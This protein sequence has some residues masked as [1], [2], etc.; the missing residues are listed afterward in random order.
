MN[1]KIMLGA[2]ALSATAVFGLTGCENKEKETPTTPKYTITFDHDNNS[3]TANQVVEVEMG[4]TELDTS[5]IPTA[6]EMNG[7]AGIWNSFT[8]NDQ[9][10]TV[11]AKYG[12]GTPANPFMVATAEQFKKILVEYSAYQSTIYAD[13]N[14]STVETEAEAFEKYVNYKTLTAVYKRNSTSSKWT[15][16]RY[17]VH[18]KVYFKM[19]EDIDLTATDLATINLAGGYFA[20]EI[21]GDGHALT[22]DGSL[23]VKTEGAMFDTVVDS[24]FKNLDIKLG[25]RLATIAG[26]ATGSET[27]FQSINLYNATSVPTYITADDNNESAFVNFV[28]NNNIITF[29]NCVNYANFASSAD[30]GGIFLGGYARGVNTLTFDNCVN[31]GIIKSAGSVGMLIGNGTGTNPANV[32][33][34]NTC[35]NLGVIESKKTSHILVSY[36]TGTGIISQ[37]VA[38]YDA[39]DYF[40]NN[41]GEVVGEIKS[42]TTAYQATVDG[43]DIIINSATPGENIAGAKYQLI[44]TAAY[45]SNASGANHMTLL[46]NITIS[47]D[48]AGGEESHTFASAF[49]GMMDLNTYNS[50]YSTNIQSMAPDRGWQQLEGYN[51]RYFVDVENGLYVLDFSE[52]EQDLG[53]QDNKLILNKTKEQLKKVIVVYNNTTSDI[54]FIVDFN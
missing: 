37:N 1:K 36:Q 48:V 15:F 44:L 21:D 46:T 38:T 33:V 26:V 10:I 41:Q 22:V 52:Y 32:V 20:G 31:Y 25:S 7:F 34:T 12:N 2:L 35:R 18:S 13:A 14:S 49:Y 39:E 24:T 50:T 3:A 19:V 40:K 53:L 11:T 5:L 6:P 27:L 16:D 45:A 47:H 42:L 28:L 9:N 17:N 30:Y 8:L 29:R 43:N 51:I 54:D 23:F 4:T